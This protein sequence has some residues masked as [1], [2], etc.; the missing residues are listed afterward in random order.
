M[1]VIFDFP[2][3]LQKDL[4]MVMSLI[5]CIDLK[6]RLLSLVQLFFETHDDHMKDK[7]PPN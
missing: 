6:E 3:R 2:G 5:K 4:G 7:E 1:P